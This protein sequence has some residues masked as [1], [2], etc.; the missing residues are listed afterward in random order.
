MNEYLVC[1]PGDIYVIGGHQKQGIYLVYVTRNIYVNNAET[2]H[3]WCV[4]QAISMS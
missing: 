1:M 3:T 2:M 4:C